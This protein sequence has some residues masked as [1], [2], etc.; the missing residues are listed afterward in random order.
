MSLSWNI[1]IF[2]SYFNKKLFLMSLMNS[3]IC[4]KTFSTNVKPLKELISLR[5]LQEK[6]Y[7]TVDISLTRAIKLCVMTLYSKFFVYLH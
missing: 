7:I 2:S 5:H 4:L 3:L 1:D 6:D